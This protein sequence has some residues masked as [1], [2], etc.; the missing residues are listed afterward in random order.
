MYMLQTVKNPKR[1]KQPYHKDYHNN[2]I[3]DI[4]NGA[5]HGNIVIHQPEDDSVNN[6]DDNYCKNGMIVVFKFCK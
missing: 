4:F 6:Q 3:K 2:G 1:F 5:L